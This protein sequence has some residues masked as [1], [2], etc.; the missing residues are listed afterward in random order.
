MHISG[1]VL[2]GSTGMK[3]KQYIRDIPNVNKCVNLILLY[4]LI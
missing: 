4:L 3:P 1:S 2:Y